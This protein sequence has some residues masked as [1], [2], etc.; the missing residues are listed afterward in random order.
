MGH[1]RSKEYDAII[2]NLKGLEALE[3]SFVSPDGWIPYSLVLLT[4]EKE[5]FPTFL[6]EDKLI[7]DRL[8]LDY[9]RVVNQNNYTKILT[10]RKYYDAQFIR[11]KARICLNDA[12]ISGFI[13]S[14]IVKYDAD[15][16]IDLDNWEV[17]SSKWWRNQYAHDIDGLSI[18]YS[19]GGDKIRSAGYIY[20]NRKEV[21][22]WGRADLNQPETRG[23]KEGAGKL[24]D[25]A[26]LEYMRKIIQENN[27]SPHRAAQVCVE[28]HGFT[29]ASE[30]ADI[31]RLGR[32]YRAKLK[33]K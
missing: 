15:K 19:K 17:L 3:S 31:D 33:A 16:R 1:S 14:R 12:L 18:F 9:E 11:T 27:I 13:Q 4:I 21:E 28:K 32:A 20:L 6:C 7:P 23:R 24:N 22:K 25:T 8:A 2:K 5:K 26:S 30:E 29:G 10:Q